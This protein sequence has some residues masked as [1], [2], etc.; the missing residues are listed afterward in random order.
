MKSE[1]AYFNVITADHIIISEQNLSLYFYNI[2][3]YI[4]WALVINTATT[5]T[6]L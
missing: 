3:H 6:N 2:F 5:W 1:E 4:L